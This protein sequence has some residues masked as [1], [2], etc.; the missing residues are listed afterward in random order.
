LRPP[1]NQIV[2]LVLCDDPFFLGVGADHPLAGR[3]AVTLSELTHESWVLPLPG[4]LFH[5]HLEGLF[6][7]AGGSWP[8]DAIHTNSLAL[9]ERLVLQGRRIMTM[10]RL[11]GMTPGGRQIQR[12]PLS[13]AGARRIGLR[14]RRETTL[15]ALGQAVIAA[16]RDRVGA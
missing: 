16:A 11:Q 3:T 8:K 13:G 2:E 1:P 9:S 5:R 15:S 10:T 12:I 6:M 7:A 4:S 14:H